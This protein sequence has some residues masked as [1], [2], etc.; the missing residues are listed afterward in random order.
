[1]LPGF[2]RVSL[3]S[4]LR[5]FV[6]E[7]GKTAPNYGVK[8]NCGAPRLE[9]GLCPTA[10]FDFDTD[11]PGWKVHSEIV[12]YD[13]AKLNK[14]YDQRAWPLRFLSGFLSVLEL[15]FSGASFGYLRDGWR[16]FLFFLFPFFLVAAALVLV[17]VALLPPAYVHIAHVFWSVPLALAGMAILCVVGKRMHVPLMMDLWAI[18]VDVARGRRADVDQ[19]LA[20]VVDDIARRVAQSSADE[21]I[22]VGHSFGA[23]PGVLA[24][25][26]PRVSLSAQVRSTGLLAAGSYL[27][28]VAHHPAAKSLREAA[29]R[30]LRGPVAWLDAQ[31]HTDPINFFRTNPADALS[32]DV[33]KRPSIVEVRF[34]HQLRPE[35][36]RAIRGD[37]FRTHR[38]FVFGVEKRSHYALFAIIGGPERFADVTAR[39][40]LSADWS[41]FT[42][43]GH[44]EKG[45][46]G[47]A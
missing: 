9:D 20:F 38:Q 2:E 32:V 37:F 25:A 14:M 22:V 31:S 24:L 39:G 29:R 46:P 7:A 8:F 13:L 40:G 18:T 44:R 11:G 19:F 12:F 26:D 6:R 21:I 5:R 33:A 36:Y 17:A 43:A 47:N 16:F 41:R 3:D 45:M 35:S 4:H 28:A 27:L 10:A 23:V 1:M 42:P 34:K 30:V 15:F